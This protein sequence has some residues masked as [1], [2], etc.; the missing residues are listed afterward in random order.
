M[1]AMVSAALE[2]LT[3]LIL[4]LAPGLVCLP[5][6][7]PFFV[8]SFCELGGK[9][10]EPGEV[11]CLPK[12]VGAMFDEAVPSLF[13]AKTEKERAAQCAAMPM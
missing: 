4:M 13:D 1:A 10:D 5:T 7:L 11:V 3:F 9:F 6:A 8:V 2:S 12:G